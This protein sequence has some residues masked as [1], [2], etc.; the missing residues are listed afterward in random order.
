MEKPGYKTTEFWLML[1]AMVVSTL[2][3]SGA[4]GDGWIRA[5]G[6]VGD[7]LAALGY[8]GN[9]SFV[10]GKT[11]AERAISNAAASQPPDPI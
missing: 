1:A 4:F 10:K 11:S 9:R 7:M 3:A 5:L 2:A 8:A 6:V